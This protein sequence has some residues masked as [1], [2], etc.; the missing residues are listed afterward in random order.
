MKKII[1]INLSGRVIPIED[2]A[3]EKLQ[4]YIESLRRYFA[5]EEGRDEI[6]NDIESRIAELMN[7]KIRGGVHAVTDED[8]EEIIHTTGRVEDFEAADKEDET[9]EKASQQNTTGSNYA[10]TAKEKRRLYR[11]TN[12]KFLGGVCSGIASYTN[13]DPAVIR[14]L[15]VILTLATGLGILAYIVMWILLPPRDMEG[16]V[17]KRLYRNPDDKMI[18]GVAGG[19]AAYFDKNPTAIRFI[20]AAPFILNI[21]FGVFSWPFD[22]HFLFPNFVFGSLTGTFILAYIVMWIVLPEANSEYEKMEMRGE[23]VDVNRIRQNVKEGMGTMK[24]RMKEWGEEVKE[25]AQNIGSKAKEFAS[26]RGQAFA[27]E[28][29]ESARRGGYGI[30]HA[31]GVLFKAFFMF[32][33]AIIAFSLFVALIAL[34]FGGVAWWPINNFLWTSSWQQ[35][36]AWATLI[37]FLVV[38]LIGFITWIIRRVIK[39][40]SKNNYLGWTFG[41]LWAL[42]WV[43]MI[44]FVTSVIG[45][46][47]S[48]RDI[49]EPVQVNQPANGKMIVAVSQPELEFTGRYGWMNDGGD[50]WD[51]SDDTMKFAAA[52]F[53]VKASADD[54][55][56][57]NIKKYGFGKTEKEATNRAEKIK[58]DV[59]S[60]DSVLDVANGYAIDKSSKFRGQHVEVEIFVPVGKKVRFDQSVRRKLNSIHVKVKR[61]Y[62]RDRVVGIEIDDSNENDFYYQTGVDY[63]MGID[64]YLKDPSGTAVSSHSDNSEYRYNEGAAPQPKPAV[65]DS[66]QRLIDEENKKIE[67][68]K[69]E[70]ERKIRE[71]QEK[72]KQVKPT[73]R[74][75]KEVLKNN[76]AVAISPSPASSLVQWF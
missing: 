59:V 2:S 19:L 37:L 65:N 71:L 76:D 1:N 54:Q 64:G 47:R 21:L 23:K 24:D 25:S 18:A 16:Y 10:Y 27:G 58:F 11:D 7:E 6:I 33:A 49:T 8:V 30:G 15:F 29:K 53:N 75:T 12:D 41:G 67:E 45:D 48:Y 26:T 5:H 62:R 42:G 61:S 4:A 38:P 20:F 69:K 44:L 72:A 52:K 22:G 28:F 32:I 60:K 40:K 57:V 50:G 51:L 73:T 55:Y 43:A 46:F 39:A 9:A 3:Y 14:L 68:A 36:L 63:V 70:S 66:I 13:I 31:I 56:H 74:I 34:L 35:F 17:G